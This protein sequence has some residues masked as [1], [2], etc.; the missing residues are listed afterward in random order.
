MS[1]EENKAIAH[2][3]YE[4]FNTGNLALADELII[5]DV[6]EH[7]AMPGQ[8]PGLAGF[9]QFVTISRAA[10]PD[11]Q[12]T[13]EDMIAERD[14]VVARVTI[15]GTHTGEFMGM[16]PTSKSFT[17]S[18]IDI[19]RFADGKA[20][21]HWG[22]Q[23]DLGMMQQLGVIPSGAAEEQEAT[24][25]VEQFEEQETDVTTDIPERLEEAVDQEVQPNAEGG[26]SA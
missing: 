8:E 14:K 6:V 19:I 4:V 1:T 10:F 13:V 23:D 3:I 18:A 25:T 12:V 17:V 22:N 7:Q 20:V 9:K 21:E 24:L 26:S 15:R 2:R 16:P 11:I 5:A